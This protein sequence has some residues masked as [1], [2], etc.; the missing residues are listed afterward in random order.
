MI[1]IKLKDGWLR[2]LLKFINNLFVERLLD[3]VYTNGIIKQMAKEQQINIR[4]SK[5]E[6]QLLAKDALEEQRSLSNLLL[7]CW[8]EWRKGKREK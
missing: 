1:F 6:K 2:V 5:E 8:K 3:N 4:L 7:W